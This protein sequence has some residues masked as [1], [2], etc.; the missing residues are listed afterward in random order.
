VRQALLRERHALRA[1]RHG[2]I[3]VDTSYSNLSSADGTADSG[4]G[5]A[6]PVEKEAP[7]SSLP[8]SGELAESPLPSPSPSSSPNSFGQGVVRHSEDLVREKNRAST[9]SM[10][11]RKGFMGRIHTLRHRSQGSRG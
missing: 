4:Y 1:L 2:K 3:T 6:L 11:G 7:V 9:D 5:S 8:E 10:S